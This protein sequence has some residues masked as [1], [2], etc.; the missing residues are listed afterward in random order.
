MIKLSKQKQERLG[1]VLAWSEVIKLS[2]Q[3]QER[4][5]VVLAWSLERNKKWLDRMIKEKGFAWTFKRVVFLNRFPAWYNSGQAQE[6]TEYMKDLRA[7]GKDFE[8]EQK[9]LKEV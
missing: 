9:L 1:V 6:L 3:K 5:G 7:Q 8:P 2:K 4:L